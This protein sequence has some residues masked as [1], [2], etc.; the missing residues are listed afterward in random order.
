MQWHTRLMLK[1]EMKYLKKNEIINI[2]DHLLVNGVYWLF[3]IWA[4]VV[5]LFSQTHVLP[6]LY[7][8]QFSL[9][10]E[11][12]MPRRGYISLF[13]INHI[14]TC[15]L[16]WWWMGET[17]WHIHIYTCM[18][19]YREYI[20]SL[21]F[22]TNTFIHLLDSK[23]IGSRDILYM[24]HRLCSKNTH[25]CFLYTVA[26]F[27]NMQTNIPIFQHTTGRSKNT[28]MIQISRLDV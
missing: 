27:S 18:C 3:D 19:V 4:E 8:W 9:F 25:M 21:N 23:K 26:D 2:A 6:L 14:S 13:D 15:T 22:K 24:L 11:C 16:H 28:S 20:F 10:T 17:F 12:V 7:Y 1:W 5:L